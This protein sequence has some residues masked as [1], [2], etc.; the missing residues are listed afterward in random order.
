LKS[1][2]SGGVNHW[3]PFS[4]SFV[5][6]RNGTDRSAAKLGQNIPLRLL[7]AADLRHRVDPIA[8]DSSTL[9]VFEFDAAGFVHHPHDKEDG[10]H[11]AKGIETV[12]AGQTCS[13]QQNRKGH[14]DTEIRAPLSAMGSGSFQ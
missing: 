10:Q 2:L 12:C 6:A 9:Q 1:G 11:R 7:L 4:F 13:R 5:Q 14:R 3:R 8:S